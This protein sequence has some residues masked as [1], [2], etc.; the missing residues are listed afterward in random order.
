L[1]LVTPLFSHS[2]TT[3]DKPYFWYVL[4]WTSDIYNIYDT[5]N[6]FQ[7]YMNIMCIYIYTHVCIV[8]YNVI[9]L[10]HIHMYKPPSPNHHFYGW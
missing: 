4:G 3:F 2:F 7:Q 1:F 9:N 10:I 6:I 8:K 5:F